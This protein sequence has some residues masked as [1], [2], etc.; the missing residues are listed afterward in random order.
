LEDGLEGHIGSA[1]LAR[2]LEQS[3]LETESPRHIL[4]AHPH[5]SECARCREQFVELALLDRQLKVGQLKSLKPTLVPVPHD[6]CPQPGSWR[7]IAAGLTNSAETLTYVEH[8]SRCNYC[9]PLLQRAIAEVQGLSTSLTDSEQSYIQSLASAEPHWHQRLAEQISGKPHSTFES[10]WARRWFHAIAAPRFALAG[11]SLLAIIV[12]GSWIVPRYKQQSAVDQ[13]LAHAYTE[14][15]TLELRIPGAAYGPLRVS[16]GPQ[17][18]FN[19]R[20][21]SLLKAEALIATELQSHPSDPKWLHAQANADLLE[22]KYDAAVDSLRRA[23][24]LDPQS[25]AILTDL[26]TAYYQRAEQE[27]KKED[28]GAAFENL[29]RALKL[30]PDDPVA[31]FNRALV[32]EQQFLY[33][34]A[35][36]DWDHYLRVDPNSEWAE[37][38]RNHAASVREILKRHSHIAPLLSPAAVASAGSTESARGIE[39]ARGTETEI[40][41]RIEEYLQEAVRSWLPQA[42]PEERASANPDALRALF[43][44]AKLTSQR[45]G[46]D[47]LSDLLHE[48][49]TANFSQAIIALATA[50]KANETG[51]YDISRQQALLAERLFN[52]SGNVAGRLRA[53]FELAYSNQVARR[54]DECRRAA[55]VALTQSERFNYPWLQ[56]QLGLEK[57]VCSLLGQNDWGADERVSRVAMARARDAHYDGLYLRALYFIADDQVGNGEILAGLKSVTIAL[58]R[59]WSSEVPAVR[60]YNFYNLLGGM[61][62][63]SAKEPH[64]VM[65]IWR[66]A[67]ALVDSTDNSFIRAAAHSFAARAATAVFEPQIAKQQYAQAASL[68]A[69]APRTGAI[70]DLILWNEIATAGMEAHLGQFQSGIAR[71]THV[72]DEV[73]RRSDKSLEAKFYSTLG[74]LQLRS[75][76]PQQAEEAFRPALDSVEQRL[77]SLNSEDDRITWSKEA[78]PVY[79]GIAEAEIVQGH[80]QESLDYF[81]RYLGAAS[82][83]A[84]SPINK[85]HGGLASR[86]PSLFG[87]TVIAYAA[88]PDGLAVWT[89]DDR[90]LDAQWIPQSNQA[91]QEL[92]TRFYGLASDPRSELTALQR[93]SRSLYRALIAPVEQRME[94]GRALVI[95]ADG[96]LAQV[97][98]EALIDASGH[99]LIERAPIVHS[100]GRNADASL[101]AEIPISTSLH[102]LIVGSAAA[103]G[104]EGLVPLPDVLAEAEAVAV[105]FPSSDLIKG[106]DA[107]LAAVERELPTAAVFHFSGHSL[108]STNGTGLMLTSA[109]APQRAP[110]LLSADKLRRLDLHNMQLAVLSTCNTESGRD[111]ARGF[112]SIAEAL[113][114]SGVPHVVASRW[115]VDSFQTQRFVEDF[116][117][118]ALSGKPVSEAI[119]ETSRRVMADSR[120]AHPYYWSA[121]SAYGRP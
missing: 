14:K 16:R 81:E 21:A 107:S 112:N 75:H 47:W 92:A 25:P 89:Y 78:A 60:A 120:T 22:G 79:M 72:Q 37:E 48:S 43:F 27:D 98:F 118:R 95:E 65:A 77:D 1:E 12:V 74:D 46:D 10:P 15:R 94:P 8:A 71:L 108:A 117:Q 11:A 66:E 90:G 17:S 91:L 116:Y 49:S 83:S 3:R 23:S 28:L 4:D 99:Y 61:P 50:V 69:L 85:T 96:W 5:L 121:F 19:S 80:L 102:A 86:L 51:D 100:L 93:D 59:Y 111:G 45:H 70:Q 35:L 101:H 109:K 40:D 32:S 106:A 84:N 53:Q 2:L 73:R 18:S 67:I 6:D 62:E 9:A 54:T 88:L 13:L 114:R 105:D 55:T 24:E 31:L 30:H 7:E 97:P 115:A 29:S 68:F 41:R 57:A 76:H 26:A 58:E 52:A 113:E 33:Q 103:S 82:G 87:Q 119:R 44:L 56:I 104:R 36:D 39:G 63:F 20:A 34:Q 110:V 38:A 64:F 42:F